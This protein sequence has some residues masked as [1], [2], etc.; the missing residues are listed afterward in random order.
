[1]IDQGPTGAVQRLPR[2]GDQRRMPTKRSLRG[3][4]SIR[5]ADA[6]GL[7]MVL[8]VTTVAAVRLLAGGTLVGQ[9][10]ATQFYPWYGYLG[11]QLRAFE[12]PGWNPFQFSGAPF[13]ADPQSGWTYVPAMLVFSFL[14][15]PLAA[16]V[17]LWLH[18]ALAGV[19]TYVL[20]RA[21]GMPVA[22]AV[23]AGTAYQLTGPV[24][25][26]SVCCPAAMEV[27]VWTPWVLAGA[28]LA[29]RSGGLQSRLGGWVIAGFALSQALAAWLGQG[30]YYLLLVVAGFIAY[31]T[32]ASPGGDLSFLARV[33][34]AALHGVAIAVIGFGLGAAGL[35]PRLDYV[36]RSN[37]AGGEYAGMNTWAARISGATSASVFDRLLVPTLHYPG[38]ATLALAMVGLLLARGRFAAPFFGF[39]GLAAAVLASSEPT[40]LHRLLFTVLPRFEELHQHW[41][42]RVSVVAYVAPAMLA[43]VA[44]AV[45]FEQPNRAWRQT[46]AVAV[47]VVIAFIL[48]MTGAGVPEEAFLASG[49]AVA[50]LVAF[51]T[52]PAPMLRR[53]VPLLLVTVIAADLL[54]ASRTTA[55]QA[56]YGGFHRVDIDDFYDS[57]GAANFLQA[58]AGEAPFRSFGYD[59]KLRAIQDG[60]TVLYRHEFADPATRALHV[61]NRAMLLGLHD[62]QGYNPVQVQRYVEL[63][64]ALNGH[65]QD[66]HDANVFTSGLDSPLL[67]LLN[68]RHVVIPAEL[69]SG[70]AEFQWLIEH[71][72]I[73]YQDG[74]VRVLENPQA[75]PRAWIVHDVR[76][77]APG[78]A[79]EL[80]ASSAVDPRT[81]AL[82][83]EPPPALSLPLNPSTDHVAIVEY[84]P[85]RIL[86]RASTGGAGMVIF[87]EV[88]DPGWHAFVDGEPVPVYLVDHALRG[89][90]LPAGSHQ[91]ELR[92][93]TPA[94]LPGITITAVTVAVLAAAIFMLGMDSRRRYRPGRIPPGRPNSS[95]G[96]LP[97]SRYG[98]FASPAPRRPGT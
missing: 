84:Q 86:A 47:P 12:I 60:Q 49:A 33:K 57:T 54:L 34:A 35:L 44:V 30:S 83:E 88:F 87:S 22:A 16:P 74:T 82:V 62:V 3:M 92:Y 39:L 59:P 85:D 40:P 97:G 13:A 68:V 70:Q 89:I 80:L 9:D 52:V 4:W 55:S 43:G 96:T 29:I 15:L 26:R 95:Q 17:F 38:S 11:E 24:Y 65:A 19:G 36:A 37:L 25:G 51:L 20:A 28:E 23:V 63:M 45:L 79:L 48:W 27:A 10:A 56:P 6:L 14:P 66:Y 78:Q 5:R 58:R 77:V 2:R 72:P 75:L 7:L 31:R 18:L 1:V 32:L 69:Q 73:V 61:N 46:P 94:L 91:I 81:T 90:Q 98:R 76:Q 41:P 93:R 64:A 42:E 53:A 71:F 8:A 21:L 67:D 50:I